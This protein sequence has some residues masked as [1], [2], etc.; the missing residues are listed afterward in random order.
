MTTL[1]APSPA[2]HAAPLRI[3]EVSNHIGLRQAVSTSLTMAYRG[4]LKIKHNPEQLFDVTVQP[5]LFT[6]LFAFIFGG[7]IGGNVHDY[8][9]VLIPGILVQ[10]VILTS[11]VTGTQLR[12]DMDKGVFDRFKSLPIA[13]ISALAGALIADMVRYT[14]AT[15][16]TVIVGLCL[17]YRPGGGFV[18][19]LV[20]ALVI[21][22]CSF[23]VSWI[24]ALVG[25]TG[26][27]AAGVQGISMM[28]MFPLTFMSGAFAMVSTMPG[29]LQGLNHANPIYYMVNT[30]RELMNGNQYTG[31]LAWS[32]LG[33]ALVIAIFAP[34]AVKAYMRRA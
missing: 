5:I 25:V 24:W 23:A 20:A 11:V 9:P 3:P 26:K 1:T 27:S 17:G 15:V 12:E 13:R 18:G 33:S 16:L 10:T 22:V 30:C 32:L 8:L 19:V 6:A 31:N 21:I 4:L 14:I 2:R 29:W 7:A 34:L 28:V